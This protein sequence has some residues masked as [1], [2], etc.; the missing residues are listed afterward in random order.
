MKPPFH[1]LALAAALSLLATAPAQAQVYGS[2]ANFD[3]VN[4]TGY[5]AHGFEIEIEDASYDKSKIYSVFGLDRDFGVPATSV[6]R[7]G[8]PTITDV[9]GFGVRVRYAASFIN[10]AWSVGT[11]TGPYPNAGDSCWP[12]GNAL[13]NSGTLTCDHFGIATYGTPAKTN[14]HWLVDTGGNSGTLTPITAGV[15]PVNFNYFPPAAPGNPAQVEAEIEA[16]DV[17]EVENP[18]GPIGSPYW[19]KIFVQHVDHN[20]EVQNLMHGHPDVPDDNELETEFAIFQAGDNEG[21]L[22]RKINR[23]SLNPGDAAL[24]LRYEFYRYI[25][26]LKNDGSIDCSGKNNAPHGVDDCGGLGDYVGAQMAGF[27][28]VQPELAPVPEPHTWALLLAGMGL[29]GLRT[30]RTMR[31]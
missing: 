14:Y 16:P 24:V 7:Y 3:A 10:G 4:D 6:E 27:N 12:F 11:P 9:A 31:R 1:P 29:V 20:V 26:P 21:D 15:P 23:F 19:V 2:L 18:L 28:V 8:A 22:S 13:Y 17:P 5:V 25:G 30:R